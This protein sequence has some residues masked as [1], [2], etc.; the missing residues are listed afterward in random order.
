MWV[1]PAALA[2]RALVMTEGQE[3]SAAVKLVV[4][5]LRYM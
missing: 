3:E 1:G 5:L 4:H 2:T